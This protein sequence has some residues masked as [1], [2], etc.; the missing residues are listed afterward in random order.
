MNIKKMCSLRAIA[1]I[2]LLAMA[3]SAFVSCSDKNEGDNEKEIFYT[4]TFDSN[5]DEVIEPKKVKAGGKVPEPPTPTRDGY[6]FGGWEKESGATWRFD[7]NVVKEDMTLSAVWYSSSNI[8]KHTP[9]GDHEN[10]VITGISQKSF[11]MRV[12]THI[13]GYNVIKI[14]DSAFKNA[15][16]EEITTIIVPESVTIIGEGSFEYCAGI[17]IQIEGALASVGELAFKGCDMLKEIKFAEG[18][19]IISAEAFRDCAGL[20]VVRIPKSVKTIDEN[21]FDSC[22]GLEAVVL[23]ADTLECIADSAFYNT[24]IDVLYMYGTDEEI[25]KLLDEKTEG[26]NESLNDA[27]ILVYSETKPTSEGLYDGYWY[28]DQNDQ[29]R[30]WQ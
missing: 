23:H 14:G 2:A 8:F 19:E 5:C 9:V 17:E 22:V 20:K 24:E 26:E 25:E 18:I 7:T 13:D 6:V 15:S 30:M 4:V 16:N 28:L 12:P 11:T 1:I 27:K 3:L 21:A 10:T 29:I